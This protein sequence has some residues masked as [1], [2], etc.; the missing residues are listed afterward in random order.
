[1]KYSDIDF[2]GKTVLITGAAGFIG[3]NLCMYFQ[4]TYP[5]CTV[6]AL[7]CFNSG[8]KFSNGNYKYLGSYANLLG[9]KGVIQCGD[10]NDYNFMGRL[11]DMYKF[12]YIFHQAAISD[13]TVVEQN[14]IMNTN[15][16]AYIGILEMAI[17]HKANVV[18]A[19][20]AAT[21]GDSSR[22]ELGSERPIKAVL[23]SGI[24]IG[25]DLYHRIEGCLHPIDSIGIEYGDPLTVERICN[26]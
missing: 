22:F 25:T 10:I 18:Y 9:F 8:E 12:D 6:I 16:N 3:S 11:A 21:Y 26:E 13:T 23:D 2:N 1:M 17:K 19:S 24:K 15:V 5:K 20:S 7:D 14:V 4:T